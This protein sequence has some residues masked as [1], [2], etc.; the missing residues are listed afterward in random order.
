M[1]S[2]PPSTPTRRVTMREVAKAADVSVQTVSNLLNGRV[3]QM[4]PETQLRIRTVMDGLGYHPNSAAR[5]LRSARSQTIGF[6]ILDDAARYLADPMTDLFMS[7][8][9][10]VLRD[11]GF[12][13]LIQASTLANPIDQL[14]RPLHEG[15]VDGAVVSLSGPP[16]V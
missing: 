1:P 13:L 12:A 2:T 6:L 11:R 5:G 8:L 16:P 10:D 9:G 4:T 3:N 7:G 14:L 15:R